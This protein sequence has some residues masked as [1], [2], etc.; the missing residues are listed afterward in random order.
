MNRVIIMRG[1]YDALG[2]TAEEKEEGTYIDWL[3][4]NIDP[5]EVR[6]YLNYE[7]GGL[8]GEEK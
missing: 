5:G 4:K 3:L 1:L 2:G 8:P 6:G 7:F